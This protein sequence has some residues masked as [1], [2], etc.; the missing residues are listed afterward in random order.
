MQIAEVAKRYG[1]T[2]DTIRY[3]ERI[4]LVPHVTRLPNGI[5]DFAEYDCGWVEFIRCMRESGVQIEALVEYVALFQEGEHTAAARLEILEEQRAKLV[6][7]LEEMQATAKRLDAKIASYRP[8]SK[9]SD[10][11]GEWLRKN[12]LLFSSHPPP[13]AKG[14][15]P[16]GA[17]FN[18]SGKAVDTTYAAPPHMLYPRPFDASRTPPDRHGIYI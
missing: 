1:I 4:G 9:C 11:G 12:S 10:G 3:Y 6:A 2:V 13:N 5:R 7:K 17:P 14:A 8:G 18:A 16:P 15:P